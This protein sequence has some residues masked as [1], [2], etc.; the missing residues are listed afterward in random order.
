MSPPYMHKIWRNAVSSYVQSL[1]SGSH[2]SVTII[3][4]GINSPAKEKHNIKRSGRLCPNP[5]LES[6]LLNIY[7]GI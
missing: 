5:H 6:E 1:L 4:R 3:G 7:C 2:C